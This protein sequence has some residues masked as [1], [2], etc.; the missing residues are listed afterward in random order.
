MEIIQITLIQLFLES[1]TLSLK[2]I[3]CTFIAMAIYTL[4]FNLVPQFTCLISRRSLFLE[5]FIP[6]LMSKVYLFLAK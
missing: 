5:L 3:S 2:E 6:R 4:M 1:K